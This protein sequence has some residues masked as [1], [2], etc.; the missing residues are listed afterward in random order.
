MSIGTSYFGNRIVRHVAADMEALAERGFTGVLHTYTENDLTYYRSTLDEI[1]RRSQEAGLVVQIGPWGVCRMFGGEAESGFVPANMELGQVLETGRRV[2]AGCPNQPRV[3]EFVRTWIDA[4]VDTGAEYVFCDEPHWTHPQHFG[5]D[6]S[7]WGCRCEVCRGLFRERF[8]GDMPVELTPEV[9]AFREDSWSTSSATSSP[10]SPPRAPSRRSARCR[11][12]RGR[13]GSRTGRGWPRCPACTRSPPT[14]TGRRSASRSSR[15]CAST[16]AASTTSPNEHDLV[17]QIWIQGFGIP[18]ADAGDI[19]TAVRI[20]REEGVENLWVWGYEACGHMTTLAPDDPGGRVGDDGGGAAGGPPVKLGVQAALVG[21]RLVPGDVE[22]SDGVVS[23]VALS[24]GNGRG[25]AAPG[26]VDLQVNGFA[27]V[28]LIHADR[29]GYARAGEAMLATGTTAFQPTFIT[30]P[31][32]EIVAALR[33]MPA[34]GV[35]PRVLG[36]HLEGPF[37]SPER[38]GVHDPDSRRDPDTRAAAP[39]ARRRPG[40]PDDARAR[41]AGRARADRRARRPRHHPVGRAHRRGRRPGAPRVRP[42]RAH[43]HA[44]LQR[45]APEHRARPGIAFAALTRPDVVVQLIVDYHHLA[46]DTVRVAW[47]AAAGRFALVTDAVAAA[48]M[49]D[50]EYRL[51]SRPLWAEDGMVRGPEGQLGGS[52]LTMIEAVRNLH[53]LGVSLED[54][55]TAA[56]TVPARVAGRPGPGQDRGRRPGGPRDPG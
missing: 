4:A 12:P 43:R 40:E 28:D 15:S 44:P 19:A 30:A 51:G 36:A 7:H 21:G 46:P 39:A 13:T 20:A 24:N 14:R 45:D 5:L 2:P 47:Q 6:P 38:L 1:V 56:S 9:L 37:I 8:G 29:D 11:T 18:A 17:P 35:G 54:A 52:A 16:R 55:L 34:D 10:T 22:V 42:R 26:F 31:E 3:R 27:G 33:A 49:G 53:E 25:I 23:A 32:P 48:A 41:A 50:G